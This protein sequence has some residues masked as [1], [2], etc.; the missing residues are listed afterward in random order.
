[1]NFKFIFSSIIQRTS[2]K[3]GMKI[4]KVFTHFLRTILTK[5]Q[6]KYR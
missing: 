2:T 4:D 5:Y 3:L 1:M 6:I